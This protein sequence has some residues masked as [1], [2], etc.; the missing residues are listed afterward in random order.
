MPLY[1]SRGDVARSCSADFVVFEGEQC[2]PLTRV[3]LLSAGS[4]EDRVRYLRYL[5]GVATRTRVKNQVPETFS[6]VF[7]R[8]LCMH[9]DRRRRGA[10]TYVDGHRHRASG[11]QLHELSRAELRSLICATFE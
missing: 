7:G 3:L 10:F 11:I 6:L 5:S 1:G 9:D 8:A 2:M 4:S